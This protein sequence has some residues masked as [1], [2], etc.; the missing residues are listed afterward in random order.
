MT[1]DPLKQMMKLIWIHVLRSKKHSRANMTPSEPVYSIRNGCYCSRALS[2][3]F[4]TISER[5][6]KI[7]Y[8]SLGII[9]V[10][11][12]PRIYLVPGFIEKYILW[13]KWTCISTCVISNFAS[14][15]LIVRLI[16]HLLRKKSVPG[17]CLYR[18]LD[19]VDLIDLY[20]YCL[21]IQRNFH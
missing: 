9:H 14:V 8:I 11:W 10:G 16:G 7:I 3:Q 5:L 18:I 6:I 12:I 17:R 13:K 21:S 15:A 2:Y 4:A 19:P 1:L 20:K